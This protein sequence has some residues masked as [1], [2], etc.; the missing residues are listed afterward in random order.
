MK[1]FIPNCIVQG[2]EDNPTTIRS[3]FVDN[4]ITE[5]D[6]DKVLQVFMYLNSYTTNNGCIRFNLNDLIHKCGFT[7]RTGKGQN[8]EKFKMILNYLNEYGYFEPNQYKFMEIKPSQFIEVV[9]QYFDVDDEG[10]KKSFVIVSD[11]EVKAIENLNNVDNNKVLL[12][13]FSLK[14]RI[15]N[16]TNVCYPSAEDVANDILLSKD[17]FYRYINLLKEIDM[18]YYDNAGVFYKVISG[19]RKYSPANNT[20][21]LPSIKSYKR[22]VEQSI[23]E[24]VSY[25]NGLGWKRTK[26]VQPDNR[27]LAGTINR[28]THLK[29]TMGL[30]KKQEKSLQDAINKRDS[31]K[32]EDRIKFENKEL[33][34][35]NEGKILSEI[36]ADMYMETSADKYYNIELSLELINENQDLLVDWDYYKH[37]MINYT[38][39]E[40]DY[41]YN[42]VQKKKRDSRKKGSFGNKNEQKN[43]TD[44]VAASSSEH[45][46]ISNNSI[47]NNNEG[48]NDFDVKVEKY[49]LDYLVKRYNKKL[50]EQVLEYP[51]CQGEEFDD[52]ETEQQHHIIETMVENYFVELFG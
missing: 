2:N 33:L 29:E 30:T 26:K 13:Y 7:P 41:Y 42:C 45:I 48:I 19:E 34:E 49:K 31:L 32:G 6:V 35:Q 28:L 11:E 4:V 14:S 17:V 51:E 20:Y 5:N 38:K 25:M 46:E 37:T 12:V 52:L 24:Y 47:A 27:Q 36:F 10:N 3:M 8:N 16:E 1:Y 9:P 18:I 50:I 39:E 21:T 22:Y 15:N 44:E 23:E 40:H 43:I